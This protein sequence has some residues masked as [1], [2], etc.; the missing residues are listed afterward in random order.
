M[1]RTL[2]KFTVLAIALGL[3]ASAFAAEGG[4]QGAPGKGG[5]G[6]KW[7]RRGVEPPAKVVEKFDTN[8]DGQIDEA[9]RQAI[10]ETVK[11]R[12]LEKFDA[13][14]DGQLDKAERQ[15]LREAGRAQRGAAGEGKGR[16]GKGPQAKG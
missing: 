1:T 7:A 16:M 3:S 8:G 4:G 15:A 2:W 10:R 12:I 13:N 11:A 9:E 6:G 14:G 5:K